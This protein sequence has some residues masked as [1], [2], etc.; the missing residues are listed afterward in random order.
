MATSQRDPKEVARILCSWFERALSVRDVSVTEVTI[1]GDTGFSNE[2]ILFDATWTKHGEHEHRHLVARIA[3]SSYQVFPD[4]TFALQFQVM[5]ALAGTTV[6]IARVHWFETDTAWFGQPFWIMERVHGAIPSDQPPYALQ[7][8]LADAAPAEQARVWTSGVDAM[9]AVHTVPLDE[10]L[11]A[12][13]HFGPV[14]SEPTLAELDRYE[15]FLHWAEPGEP[16]AL[17][18]V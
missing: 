8:W 14:A 7:G 2:T 9:A 3:P 12:V 17:A 4:D 11:L 16:H 5:R 18:R 13:G 1:P 15:R 6:P 10:I